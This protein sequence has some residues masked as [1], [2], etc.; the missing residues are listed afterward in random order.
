MDSTA[1]LRRLDDVDFASGLMTFAFGINPSFRQLATIVDIDIPGSVHRGADTAFVVYRWVYP[2]DSLLT[3]VYNVE[4]VTRCAAG[5]CA[6]VPGNLGGLL[7]LLKEPM[8]QA[9]VR[10]GR[11]PSR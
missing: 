2:K 1:R 9:P 6:Q 5:W 10:R 4:R 3:L 11:P 8:V 7:Q